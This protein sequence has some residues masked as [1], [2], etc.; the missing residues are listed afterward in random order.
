MRVTP[1]HS[2]LLRRTARIMS[3]AMLGL[4][5]LGAADNPPPAALQTP[6]AGAAGEF[7]ERRIRPLLAEQCF[8]CHSDQA[9]KLKG[10]LR[11][12]SFAAMI[13]GGESKHPAIVPGK[14]EESLVIKAMRYGDEDLQMPPKKRLD[15]QAIQ[16]MATWISMGAPF[17]GGD[18]ASATPLKR[19]NDGTDPEKAKSFWSFQP[20][21]A[22][23]VPAVKLASWPLGDIDRLVLARMEALGVQPAPEADKRTLIRRASFDL[24]GLPPSPEEIDAFLADGSPTAFA[25]VVDRL[26]ASPRYGERWGRHWLDL[27]R[28]A[29]T[30]G[31]SADYPVPQAYLY[32]DWVIDAFNRDL[33]YDEFLRQQIAGDLLPARDDAERHQHLIATGFIAIAKR[34]SVNPE[35]DQYL[36]IEDTIDTLG[37]SVLGLTVGCARCHDHKFDPIPSSD[38]YGLYGIFA[39]THYPF[40]G[41]EEDHR[42]RGLVPLVTPTE[43]EAILG[44]KK[45]QLAAVE[46]EIAELEEERTGAR[47]VRKEAKEAN[48]A[49]EQAR[50][51]ANA[52][53]VD[54]KPVD[55]KTADAKPVEA[56]SAD[57]AKAAAAAAASPATTDAPAPAPV[58]KRTEAELKKAIAD[59]KKRRS[60]LLEKVPYA[61]A[62]SEGTPA[63]A[64]V[65]KRGDPDKQGEVVPRH[66]LSILG[67]E[68][69]PTGSTGSGRLELARW[70]SSASNPLTARVMA[71]RLWQY[72]FGTAI[73]ATPSDFGSRGRAPNNPAL[74][75]YLASQFIAHGWSFKAM[76]R[77]IMLSRAWQLSTASDPASLARDAIDD[78]LW[79]FPRRRLE[80]EEI[81]DSI[82]AVSGR[83]DLAIPAGHPFPSQSS[84]EFS[85]HS[86]FAAVYDSLHRSVYVMQ[87]RI[88]KHPFFAVFDGAD[89]GTST[90][91]RMVSTS[92]L[93]ALFLMNDPFVF[94]QSTAFAERLSGIADSRSRLDAAFRL[95][96]A[97]HATAAEL[98][99]GLAFLKRY[100]ELSPD[101]SADL[102]ALASYLRALFASNEF[103]FID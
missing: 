45:D 96:L 102:P 13:Q 72:H 36:T 11:L 94:S 89:T 58:K 87:Q 99:A 48:E 55:A 33:P 77:A 31:D 7:F 27:V 59:A 47:Q 83:L 71:N 17:P 78:T 42:P 51:A 80:A 21:A 2:K 53:P 66:F 30:A 6:G 90:A 84:W 15:D 65:Q 12:D 100:H 16:D 103:M 19:Q 91:E 81:R 79:R 28:Y 22:P 98:D 86:Q 41:S 3:A 39:S 56:T 49:K 67:G 20:I 75:D 93:Q 95:A 1:L 73:V 62:V 70:L 46:A 85:Q 54:A 18:A 9:K 68:R 14:P 4:G 50:P 101:G 35:H 63:D 8:Q 5:L 97:R 82:L 24:T 38:Y 37:K 44:P 69:L 32:R 52:K 74:L 40:A 57:A 61:F 26:L 64:H 29:D 25:T 23:A 34:Y 76:H 92:P 60:A 43:L 10:G 88:R